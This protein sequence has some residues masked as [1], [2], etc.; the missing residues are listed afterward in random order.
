M[1]SRMTDISALVRRFRGL[2][3]V[4]KPCISAS[5]PQR[6]LLG[7]REIFEVTLPRVEDLPSFLDEGRTAALR[8]PLSQRPD[9]LIDGRGEFGF[10]QAIA[11]VVGEGHGR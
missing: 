10:A 6:L 1:L 7:R 5:A 8:A 11:F 2:W 3:V 4:N 9:L